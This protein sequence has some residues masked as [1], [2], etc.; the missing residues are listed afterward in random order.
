MEETTV[1]YDAGGKFPIT[2]EESS[3]QRYELQN[4]KFVR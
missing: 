1:N 2:D 3:I 4:V